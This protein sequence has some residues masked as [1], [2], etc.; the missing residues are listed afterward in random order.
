M[1]IIGILTYITL[2]IAGVHYAVTLAIFAGFCELL[3][4]VGPFLALVPAVILALSQGG[5]LFMLVVIAIY[6]GIQ[7]LENNVIVPLV[8][9]KAVG[10]S[11][12]II[13]FAMLV[14]TSFPKTINPVVGIIISLPIATA[15][16]V[17]VSDYTARK[18]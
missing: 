18:K 14:G 12:V 15:I 10:L 11:P 4:Y 5:P 16:S 8:M 17:F 6:V 13:M 2:T 1:L 9:K 7:Q 3:P